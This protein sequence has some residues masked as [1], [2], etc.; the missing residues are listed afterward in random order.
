[1]LASIRDHLLQRRQLTVEISSLLVHKRKPAPDIEV[2][3]K[4][5]R[6]SKKKPGGPLPSPFNLLEQISSR[7]FPLLI[8]QRN[9]TRAGLLR[10]DI[11]LAFVKIIIC[12]RDP[13]VGIVRRLLPPFGE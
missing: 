9:V 6:P 7:Y 11:R 8:S 2:I 12:A 5:R 10:R 3:A 1:M 13:C 4:F